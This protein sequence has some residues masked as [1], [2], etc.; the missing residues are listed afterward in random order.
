MWQPHGAITALAG[1]YMGRASG[2]LWPGSTHDR[3]SYDVLR[4]LVVSGDPDTVW[5][6]ACMCLGLAALLLVWRRAWMPLIV[7]CIA[8]CGVSVVLAVGLGLAG[9]PTP[10]GIWAACA[11]G[12]AVE[13]W[14]VAGRAGHEFALAHTHTGEAHV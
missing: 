13:S 12:W 14:R 8:A 4:E 1:I 11:T 2:L 5:A 10:T 7:V 9:L 3:A 6:L